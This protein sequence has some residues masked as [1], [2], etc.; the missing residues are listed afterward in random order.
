MSSNNCMPFT[1]FLYY[2][3]NICDLR[4]VSIVLI[5]IKRQKIFNLNEMKNCVTFQPAFIGVFGLRYLIAVEGVFM[6]FHT[7]I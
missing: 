3:D 4:N 1:Q 5:V 7:K 6:F 2:F